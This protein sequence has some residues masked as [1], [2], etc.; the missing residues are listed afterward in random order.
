MYGHGYG[1]LI[2]FAEEASTF[3]DPI[4][5]GPVLSMVLAIFAEFFCSLALVFG[6]ATRLAAIPL[7]ILMIV[8]AFVVHVSDPFGDMELALLY[9]CS[10]VLILL[11]GPGR[12]SLDAVIWN[13]LRE[14]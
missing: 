8:I 9:L 11:A 14:E 5:L 4:G 3:E 10:F 12:Y 1:K 13:K 7:I 2:S 6:V